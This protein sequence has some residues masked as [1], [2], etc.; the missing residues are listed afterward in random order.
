M[1]NEKGSKK[2]SGKGLTVTYEISKNT[3]TLV[4]AGSWDMEDAFRRAL[5]ASDEVYNL[6]W[7][8]LV[9]NC[10]G[11][12]G[13]LTSSFIAYLFFLLCLTTKHGYEEGIKLV[14]SSVMQIDLMRTLS[15]T[16]MSGYKVMDYHQA[17]NV[18][19]DQQQV[20]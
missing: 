5:A 4:L 17:F 2:E 6:K 3:C 1:R 20:V 8:Q 9:V 12:E 13:N 18:V 15:E 16:R 11:V 19:L 7:D 14:C 10:A